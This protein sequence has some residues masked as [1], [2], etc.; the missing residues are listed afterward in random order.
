MSSGLEGTKVVTVL[1]LLH[2]FPDMSL[3]IARARS[4]SSPGVVGVGCSDMCN[5]IAFLE[6]DLALGL[7]GTPLT[8]MGTES[9]LGGIFLLS[10]AAP[11]QLVPLMALPFGV[12]I[13]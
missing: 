7:K 2:R 12:F 13:S 6:L 10:N 5:P 8:T 3:Y 11:G 1:D 9:S 4:T